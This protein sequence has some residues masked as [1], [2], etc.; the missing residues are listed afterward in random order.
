M[1]GGDC[2]GRNSRATAPSRIIH[3]HGCAFHFDDSRR[4]IRSGSE[5]EDGMKSPCAVN[6][7]NAVTVS[8]Q[9]QGKRSVRPRPA[10]ETVVSA[11]SFP[12]LRLRSGQALAKNA[13]RGT[14]ATRASV[15]SISAA[16][17]PALVS[18]VRTTFV[19]SSTPALPCQRII[20]TWPRM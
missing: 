20:S 8:Q 16:I 12:P 14:R 5:P 17:E 18:A 9:G 1:H 13:G 3:R 2:G 10:L 6:L 4:A 11:V 19:G 7:H 15:V